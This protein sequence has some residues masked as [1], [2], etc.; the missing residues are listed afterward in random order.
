MVVVIGDACADIVIRSS[1]ASVTDAQQDFTPEVTCGGSAANTAKL[2]SYLGMDVAFVGSVGKDVYGSLIK[3]TFL[4]AGVDIAGLVELAD[5]FTTLVFAMVDPSGFASL[6]SWPK[7]EGADLKLDSNMVDISVYNDI[8]WLHTTGLSLIENPIR[9]TIFNTMEYAKSM[10]VPVSF[11]LNLRAGKING[12][13]D[14]EYSLYIK[15]AIGLS[16]YV[17]GSSIEEIPLLDCARNIEQAVKNLA[18]N[19]RFVISRDG[20]EGAICTNGDKVMRTNSISAEI[21]DTIGAGDAFNAGFIAS[22]LE[23]HTISQA[24]T[25]GHATAS[26]SLQSLGTSAR[27]A[28]RDILDIVATEKNNSRDL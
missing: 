8:T 9:N 16:D 17:L 14:Q 11:D 13:I 12:K 4:S 20:A 22:I 21:E 5:E 23:G 28:R 26:L 3:E 7:R 25:W 2:L 19:Q 18:N 24:L 10:N 6:K 15:R 1:S 27:F